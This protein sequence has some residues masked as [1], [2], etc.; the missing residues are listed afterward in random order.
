MSYRTPIPYKRNTFSG[1]TYV[2]I[3]VNFV[4]L[5]NNVSNLPI[6]DTFHKYRFANIFCPKRSHLLCSLLN[7]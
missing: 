5:T 1:N 6:I 7:I 3:G 4:E 2:S